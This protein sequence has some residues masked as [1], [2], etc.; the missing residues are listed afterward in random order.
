MSIDCVV[1]PL[2]AR[3]EVFDVLDEEQQSWSVHACGEET[4]AKDESIDAR[5][6][7]PYAR[8]HGA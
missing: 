3:T 2:R 6:R 8:W 5:G 1:T 4:S 7:W